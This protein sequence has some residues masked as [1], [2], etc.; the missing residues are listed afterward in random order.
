M[1]G[2]I[3]LY[4]GSLTNTQ[5][6][7]TPTRL[8]GSITAPLFEE[9]NLF[10]GNSAGYLGYAEITSALF[11]T[12]TG[13]TNAAAPGD[14][15]GRELNISPAPAF[16]LTQS[17]DSARPTLGRIPVGGRRNQF[18]NTA[19]L[20]TQN[21]T[22]RAVEYTMSFKGTG[23]ITLTGTSTDGPLVGT[24]A[25]DRVSLTFTPTAGTL[26]CTVAGSVTEAQIQ[27][28][29]AFDAYQAV[30]AAYDVTEEGV[31][32]ILMPYYDG[33]D[34]LTTGVESFGTA[35]FFADAGQQWWV[36]GAFSN[37]AL[38]GSLITKRGAGAANRNFSVLLQNFAGAG[39]NFAVQ[40]RTSVA[41]P[42]Y[43]S[44]ASFNDGALHVWLLN[45]TGTQLFLYVDN[46]AAVEITGLG[47]AAEETQNILIGAVTES[48]PGT[49]FTG[50]NQIVG[51]GD[52]SLSA[53]EIAAEMAQ[54]NAFYRG[55]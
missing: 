47:T 54:A 32:S 34:F 53:G 18:L 3:S 21:V 8:F 2:S 22:T 13:G 17:S 6:P 46:D 10:R 24:G 55:A 42:T 27:F 31:P 39:A 1:T 26:T 43:A 38:S 37:F 40:I 48:A 36:A 11:T 15:I 29:S 9:I 14:P 25:N 44:V 33:G 50:F 35:S 51:F 45:W 20:A 52:R 19:T 41:N 49:F 4:P 5:T 12:A 30:G 16:N 23:S 7:A 28:G